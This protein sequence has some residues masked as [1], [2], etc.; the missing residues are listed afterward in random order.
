MAVIEEMGQI[1]KSVNNPFLYYN[2]RER[3]SQGRRKNSTERR[4]KTKEKPNPPPTIEMAKDVC[5]VGGAGEIVQ[6]LGAKK[7]LTTTSRQ[8]PTRIH[9]A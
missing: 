4:R 1:N 8:K 9:T 7:K 5:G 2:T 6:E 3:S